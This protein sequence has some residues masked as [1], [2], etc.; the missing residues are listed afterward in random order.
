LAL[1]DG[2]RVFLR[3]EPE[4]AAGAAS[5]AAAV[6]KHAKSEALADFLSLMADLPLEGPADGFSGSDHDRLLY[7]RP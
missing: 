6:G 2:T 7:G 5:E 4:P 1:A 3:I